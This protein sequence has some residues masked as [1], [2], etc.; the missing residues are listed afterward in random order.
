ML[1][2]MLSQRCIYCDKKIRGKRTEELSSNL[3][4]QKKGSGDVLFV[5]FAG[6]H[7]H[8]NKK[9]AVSGIVDL[10]VLAS[11]IYKSLHLIKMLILN[12]QVNLLF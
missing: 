11:E 8:G 5:Y 7:I 3:H 9:E 2:N 1:Q 12:E 6:C 4:C 10:H